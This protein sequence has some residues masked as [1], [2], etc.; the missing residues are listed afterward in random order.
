MFIALRGLFTQFC[1]K[2]KDLLYL[3]DSV[4]SSMSITA[5]SAGYMFFWYF[6]DKLTI[7]AGCVHNTS[8]ADQMI[9]LFAFGAG[10]PLATAAQTV[11]L[12]SDLQ[13]QI[14]MIW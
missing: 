4:R 2:A 12:T 14:E 1:R 7:T 13:R 10:C 8:A 5:V 11:L 3:V 9:A 6:R